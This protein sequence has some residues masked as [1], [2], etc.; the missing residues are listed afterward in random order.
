LSKDD[1]WPGPR[2]APATIEGGDLVLRGEYVRTRTSY[3]APVTIEFD[4]LF[5]NPVSDGCLYVLFVPEN[6]PPDLHPA[7]ATIFVM[8]NGNPGHLLVEQ[9]AGSVRDYAKPWEKPF[10]LLPNHVYHVRIEVLASALGVEVG[11]KTF[12]LT[13][14]R[15]PYKRFYIQLRGWHPPTHW[16][17]RNF[18]VR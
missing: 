16:I 2:A 3:S 8:G 11:G 15:V 13:D 5:E 10:E 6:S 17:V 4:T 18:V 7:N 9:H 12:D 14:V 1:D